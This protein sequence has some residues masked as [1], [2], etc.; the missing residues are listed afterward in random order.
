MIPTSQFTNK[1][2]TSVGVNSTYEAI[3]ISRIVADDDGALKI[4]QMEEFVDSKTLLE[5]IKA[6]EAAGPK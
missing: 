5:T 6:Y 1:T 4:I 3:T 2:K